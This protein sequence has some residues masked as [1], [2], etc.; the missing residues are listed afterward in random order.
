[1]GNRKEKSIEWDV[2][3]PLLEKSMLKAY[4]IDVCYRVKKKPVIGKLIF[5][6]GKYKK[7][8]E[9]L[10]Q[11]ANMTRRVVGDWVLTGISSV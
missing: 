3:I 5:Q 10:E 9:L 8:A 6:E 7:A 4:G 2:S 1:M 11:W